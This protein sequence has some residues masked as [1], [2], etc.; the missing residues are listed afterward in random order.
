MATATTRPPTPPIPPLEPGDRLTRDE[1]ERRYDAMPHLKKAELI[2]GVVHMPSPVRLDSHGEPQ[3]DVVTWL[4]VYK[5]QTP[6]IRGGDNSTIRLD[7]ENVPQPDALLLIEPTHGGQ[8]II[9]TDGYV[10]AAP[11]L[12]AEVSS[13]TVSI[14]LHDKFRLYLRNRAREYLV[15]RV[16]D[17]AVD[18]FVLRQ[19]RFERLPLST[20]GIYRSEI[21][22]GLWLDPVALANGDLVRVL[23]VLQQGLS[24]PEHT[25]FVAHLRR[26][27]VRP[28]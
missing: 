1:F 27:A 25:A 9:G 24:S 16:L 4:G 14:D 10:E 26:A 23:Q 18:W 22:P 11:E 7:M 21:L 6:G 17:R 19:D 15:W 12:V 5:A 20:D 3:M 8:A 28:A 13:S 2:D